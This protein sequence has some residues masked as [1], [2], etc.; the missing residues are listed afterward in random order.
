MEELEEGSLPHRVG[1][2]G[3]D[4]AVGEKSVSRAGRAEHA[5]VRG[6]RYG[7]GRGE[8]QSS[9]TSRALMVAQSQ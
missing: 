4:L 6:E 1:D 7:T 8:Q 9:Q 2:G 5:E 3:T